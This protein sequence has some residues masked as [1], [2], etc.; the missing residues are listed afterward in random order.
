[1]AASAAPQLSAGAS[2][3]RPL[4][5]SV[6]AGVLLGHDRASRKPRAT[7]AHSSIGTAEIVSGRSTAGLGCRDACGGAGQSRSTS[8]REAGVDRIMC[9][10]LLHDDL[11]TVEPMGAE[12][13]LCSEAVDEALQAAGLSE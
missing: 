2:Q 5:F 1:M 4:P 12:A 13:P 11:D 7:A 9:Q 3:P 10:H 6:M 8:L